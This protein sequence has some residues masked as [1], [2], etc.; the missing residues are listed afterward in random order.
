MA[1]PKKN[2][3][4]FNMKVDADVMDKFAAFCKESGQTKTCAFENMVVEH[5]VKANK[6]KGMLAVH[7]P[8]YASIDTSALYSAIG[9]TDDI[10]N[11]PN[12]KLFAAQEIVLDTIF[13]TLAKNRYKKTAFPDKH[14]ATYVF[15]K[16]ECYLA[17]Y[18]REGNVTYTVRLNTLNSQER[19]IICYYAAEHMPRYDK[20]LLVKMLQ[21]FSDLVSDCVRLSFAYEG[22]YTDTIPR[23]L[24]NTDS[25]L[26]YN[27][28]ETRI[29]KPKH[30]YRGYIDKEGKKED[31]PFDE[32]LEEIVHKSVSNGTPVKLHDS[33]TGR[34]EK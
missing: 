7:V 18:L 1:R 28:V 17:V 31:L 10:N 15:K 8:T 2:Y 19:A 27:A 20:S 12:E 4:V 24:V 16:Y 13:E 11:M 25:S 26:F 9:F 5:I 22:A 14:A 34:G 29:L 33:E 30:Y 32:W 3:R 21:D 23:G 6:D